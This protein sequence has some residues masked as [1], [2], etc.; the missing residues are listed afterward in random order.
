M[1]I[2]F[3]RIIKGDLFEHLK[4]ID[5]CGRLDE[6]GEFV[7]YGCKDEDQGRF[8]KGIL[9]Y[10]KVTEINGFETIEE[11]KEW[12]EEEADMLLYVSKDDFE[13]VDEPMQKYYIGRE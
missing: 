6:T 3:A 4:D 7:I 9:S 8:Y 2:E 11:V 5:I 13:I 10:D 12:W 1:S